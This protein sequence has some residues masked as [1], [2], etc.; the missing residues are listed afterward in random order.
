MQ[1]IQDIHKLLV[2]VKKFLEQEIYGF[3]KNPI[4]HSH[5]SDAKAIRQLFGEYIYEISTFTSKLSQYIYHIVDKDMR[6]FPQLFVF[7]GL[8]KKP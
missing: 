4:H 5:R 2:E 7:M 1:V 8:I 6:F 3:W